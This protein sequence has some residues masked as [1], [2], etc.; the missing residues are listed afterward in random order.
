MTES[1][2]NKKQK[3]EEVEW[4]LTF[5][6]TQGLRALVEVVG[7]ILSRVNFCI[8]HD[9]KKD[10]FFLCIDSIDPQH[11][12]MIQSRLL[13]E[14]THN[15]KGNESFCVDT[16]TLNTLLRNVPPHYSLDLV[17]RKNC[18]DIFMRTYESLS[19]SHETHYKLNTMVDDSEMMDL[20]DMDYRYTVEID[21]GTLRQIV[22]MSQSLRANHVS[23]SIKE[24]IDNKQGVSRT[25]FCIA[26][27]GDATQEHHFNSATQIESESGGQQD[28]YVIRAAMDATGPEMCENEVMETKYSDSFSTTYLS[29]F[30]KFKSM[31][32]QIITVKL[33]KDQP[34]ILNYPLG[35]DRSYVCF[36][37]AP[38]TEEE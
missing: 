1:S 12:C 4:C 7:N 24:P 37:L 33:S 26:S 17:K 35:A 38:K 11:V 3:T 5:D 29:H 20:P 32:R 28:S 9:T 8:K 25:T 2:S 6:Q 27:T 15:L 16:N 14:K 21:L 30:L 22:K 18:A 10:I 36:V 34:L 13:C 31:E 19:N 23:F